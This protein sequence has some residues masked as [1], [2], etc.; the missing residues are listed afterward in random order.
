MERILFNAIAKLRA[1]HNYG[2]RMREI[3]RG[4]EPSNEI[5]DRDLIALMEADYRKNYGELPDNETFSAPL[6]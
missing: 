5:S 4:F 1:Y 3:G 6:L 2:Q